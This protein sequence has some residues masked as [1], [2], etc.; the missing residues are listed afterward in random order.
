MEDLLFKRKNFFYIHNN[1]NIYVVNN[2]LSLYISP[3][4][5]AILK[6]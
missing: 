4:K 2:I 6:L 3:G 1:E 5:E